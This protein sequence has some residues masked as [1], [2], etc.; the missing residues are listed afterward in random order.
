MSLDLL[1]SNLDFLFD[2]FLIFVIPILACVAALRFSAGW[3][4]GRRPTWR[5]TLGLL[6]L[7]GIAV[8][9]ISF[10]V[11][12]GDAARAEELGASGLVLLELWLCGAVIFCYLLKKGEGESAG[13]WRGAL[14]ALLA[15]VLQMI[16]GMLIVFFVPQLVL[17]T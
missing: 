1:S 16:A 13:L 11:S 5:R 9:L 17:A 14:V 12:G 3:V 10:V 7:Q 8:V 15:T 4:L 6:V 2:L